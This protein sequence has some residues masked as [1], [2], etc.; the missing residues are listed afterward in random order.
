VVVIAARA[1]W[2]S[3]PQQW[4]RELSDRP[5]GA[6]GNGDHPVVRGSADTGA[7]QMRR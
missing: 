4:T 6:R 3:I 1:S 5:Q 2:L 7:D